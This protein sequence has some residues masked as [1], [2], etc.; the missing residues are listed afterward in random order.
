MFLFT[1][2]VF[3][4]TSLNTVTPLALKCLS[5]HLTPESLHDDSLLIDF[6]LRMVHSTPAL[7]MWSNFGLQR[8]CNLL[9]CRDSEFNYIP[10]KR[11][12]VLIW[13]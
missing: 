3:S 10:L 4:F 7:C 1:R 12:M 6:P 8:L 13:W 5:D 2:S 9:C 11:G